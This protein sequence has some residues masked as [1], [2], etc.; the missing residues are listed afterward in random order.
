MN[1]ESVEMELFSTTKLHEE[2]RTK[3]RKVLNIRH[4]TLSSFVK[5]LCVLRG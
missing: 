1:K 4:L 5:K 3:T 2:E